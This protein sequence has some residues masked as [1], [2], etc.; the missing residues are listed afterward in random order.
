M[1]KIHSPDLKPGVLSLCRCLPCI[2]LT[3][4]QQ[5]LLAKSITTLLSRQS[6]PAAAAARHVASQSFCAR[7]Q[8]GACVVPFLPF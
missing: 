1:L 8:P 5:I 4:E 2:I 7:S 6:D 3:K